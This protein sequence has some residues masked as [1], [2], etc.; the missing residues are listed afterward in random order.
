M[1]QAENTFTI[2]LNQSRVTQNP[3]D[4]HIGSSYHTILAQQDEIIKINSR[5]AEIL[6]VSVVISI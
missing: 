4:F 5:V 6:T 3:A 2:L 1:Q